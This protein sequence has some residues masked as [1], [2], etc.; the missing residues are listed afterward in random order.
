MIQ[1]G[2][3]EF[4]NNGLNY[5]AIKTTYRF[6]H[7]LWKINSWVM[8]RWLSLVNG[9]YGISELNIHRKVQVCVVIWREEMHVLTVTLKPFLFNNVK[10]F[11][12]IPAWKVLNS[13]KF[14]IVSEA[15]NAHLPEKPE[16]DQTKLFKVPLVPSLQRIIFRK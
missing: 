14:P 5:S 13:D 2:Q 6:E 11:V 1:I 16:K 8:D 3:F 10:W 12:L 4:F 9:V 7:V 15:R